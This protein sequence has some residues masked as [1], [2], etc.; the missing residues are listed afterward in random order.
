MF[1]NSVILIFQETLEAAILMSVLL[2]FARING[3]RPTWII[4]AIAAGLVGALIFAF[5]MADISD[6]FDYVGQEVMNA[7]IQLIIIL[8]LTVFIALQSLRSRVTVSRHQNLIYITCMVAVV[9]LAMT[10]EGSE[11]FIYIGMVLQQP[12]YIRPTLT[13]T[14]I[15][16]GIGISCGTLL[17]YGLLGLPPR[18]AP[19]CGATL[20]A[21][22]SGNFAS[23]AILNLTQAD[24]LPYTK[25]LWDSSVWLPEGSLQG[26]LL[27]AFFGYEATPSILQGIAYIAGMLFIGLSAYVGYRAAVHGKKLQPRGELV[28]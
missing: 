13:G 11:I 21:L 22:V 4:F 23:Q 2:V 7:L 28:K 18:W 10:R 9:S 8:C 14:G 16:A 24:W 6:W 26:H 25:I 12:E 20:L 3:I 15:G 19:V 17:Y 1:L 5:N 27:F